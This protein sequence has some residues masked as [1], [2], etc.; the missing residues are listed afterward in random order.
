[1]KIRKTSRMCFT[2]CLTGIILFSPALN[3]AQEDSQVKIVT[4]EIT[5]QVGFVD[6][7]FISIIYKKEEEQ[8]RE[9]EM[10]LYLQEGVIVENVTNNDLRKLN[11]EDIVKVEYTEIEK[12]GKT[13]RSAKRI[14]FLRKKPLSLNLKG[15]KQ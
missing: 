12:A 10:S 2:L 3:Y 9:Y 1:M 11:K 14:S 6:K 15:F 8:G 5:G 4:K 13:E 7:D